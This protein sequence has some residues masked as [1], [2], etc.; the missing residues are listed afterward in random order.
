MGPKDSKNREASQTKS[1]KD[2]GFAQGLPS[3][4]V[5]SA[6]VCQDTAGLPVFS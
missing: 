5:P 2:G 4:P 1:G 6:G 3:V